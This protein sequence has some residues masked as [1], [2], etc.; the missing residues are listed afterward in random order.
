[1]TEMKLIYKTE[2]DSQTKKNKL[3]VTKRER[4][5]DK[6]EHGLADRKYYNKQ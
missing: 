5:S 4:G 6:L 2:A 1:M 3:M